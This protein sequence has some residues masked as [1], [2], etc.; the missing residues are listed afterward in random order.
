M[1]AVPRQAASMQGRGLKASYLQH[2]GTSGEQGTETCLG[3]FK[4]QG[5]L[6]GTRGFEGSQ[7]HGDKCSCSCCQSLW[8]LLCAGVPRDGLQHSTSTALP[9]G[10]DPSLLCP[11]LRKGRFQGLRL[12]R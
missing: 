9:G 3:C 11:V 4:G 10:P 7:G 12:R 1:D 6:E 8:S 5:R 2:T